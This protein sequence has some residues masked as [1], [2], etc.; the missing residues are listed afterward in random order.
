MKTISSLSP[1]LPPVS[2]QEVSKPGNGTGNGH[3]RRPR[4]RHGWRLAARR[5]FTG[6]NLRREKGYSL[7]SAV[8]ASGSNHVYVRAMQ[9]ILASEDENLLMSVLLGQV[10]V[11]TA[12]A[13]VRGLAA[14]VNAYT[15]ASASMKVAFEVGDW[16]A[17]AADDGNGDAIVLLHAQTEAA[18]F[19]PVWRH[20]ACILFMADRIFFHKSDGTRHPHNSGAPPVLVA[21]GDEAAQRLYRCGIAGSLVTRWHVQAAGPPLYSPPRPPLTVVRPSA[22]ITEHKSTVVSST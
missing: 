4:I 17:M 7:D 21:F 10:P 14:L 16:V 9:S 18:W 19:T 5:A 12:A 13:Q 15:T 3:R 22:E 8:D 2:V 20:A 1:T 6:A 11:M